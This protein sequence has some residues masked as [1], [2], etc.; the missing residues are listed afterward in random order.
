ME[1]C[2]YA[3]T[4]IVLDD[5][6]SVRR[7][8]L[9]N[10]MGDISHTVTGDSLFNTL[11]KAFLGDLE[12]LCSFLRNISDSKRI[13]SISVETVYI[14]SHINAHNI[15]VLDVF[16]L[17]RDTMDDL[18][19]YRNARRSGESAVSQERGSCTVLNDVIVDY[20]IQLISGHTDFY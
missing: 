20:L 1:L 10:C 12:K 2:A 18:V 11:E 13:S 7:A 15:A 8:V 16:M 5:T 9:L 19:V 3:V 6:V 14:S 4:D 17:G